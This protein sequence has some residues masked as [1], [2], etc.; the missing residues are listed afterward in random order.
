MAS[1]DIDRLSQMLKEKRGKQ[2]LRDTAEEIGDVSIS[3][4]SRIEQGKIPDLSTF[5]KICTWLGVSPNEFAPDFQMDETDH[6][7]QILYH[8]RADNALSPEVAAA[9]KKMIEIAYANSNLLTSKSDE[10]RI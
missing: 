2:N 10:E 4:L 5:L 3:T 1:I 7:R 6:K 8:L 9:L